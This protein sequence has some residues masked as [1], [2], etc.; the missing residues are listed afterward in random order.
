MTDLV[1]IGIGFLNLW[2]IFNLGHDLLSI[3]H[4]D[5]QTFIPEWNWLVGLGSGQITIIGEGDIVSGNYLLFLL[6]TIHLM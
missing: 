6:H 1:I 5:L 4:I 3:S 2:P